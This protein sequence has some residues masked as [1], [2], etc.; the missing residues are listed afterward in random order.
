MR[1]IRVE[2][3]GQ[4][5]NILDGRFLLEPDEIREVDDYT[6][7]N[8]CEEYPSGV[9]TSVQVIAEM[10]PIGGSCESMDE[11]SFFPSSEQCNVIL[12]PS[13][14]CTTENSRGNELSCIE[15]IYQLADEDEPE[16]E[17]QKEVLLEYE[18]ANE[19]NECIPITK[20]ISLID[21]QD[22]VD[23]TPTPGRVL[24][25]GDILSL[26]Q[27]KDVD[28]C[29]GKDFDIPVEVIVN[30]GPIESCGGFGQINFIYPEDEVC[31]LLLDLTCESSSGDECVLTFEK[32]QCN[33]H[34]CYIDFE[35]TGGTCET[36]SNSQGDYFSCMDN[37]ESETN[38]PFSQNY[39]VVQS[40]YHDHYIT[41]FSG[42]VERGSSFRVGKDWEYLENTLSFMIY[43][44]KDGVLLQKLDFDSSCSKPL[45]T[46]D[47]FGSVTAIAFGSKKHHIPKEGSA[48]NDFN[49][50][51]DIANVGLIDADLMDITFTFNGQSESP[52]DLTQVR[53]DSGS[54]YSNYRTFLHTASLNMLEVSAKVNGEDQCSATGSLTLDSN[55]MLAPT[56]CTGCPSRLTLRFTGGSCN[57]SSNHQ[58]IQCSDKATIP[59]NA[60]IIISDDAFEATFFQG[61]VSLGNEFEAVI[62]D[63]WS[64][65]HEKTV[66][67][68]MVM[69]TESPY[70]EMKLAQI[71][72][73][74][75]NCIEPLSVDDIYGALDITGW[76]NQEQ[77][78]VRTGDTE[79]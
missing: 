25:P 23:I 17:C 13:V 70:S 26:S 72:K 27:I 77:G 28:F 79:C 33:F 8:Y 47:V 42:F 50:K 52:D 36:S 6:L 11:L 21:D 73:F 55:C 14:E 59:T 74:S 56:K 62:N 12:N 18:L 46:G 9:T 35:F 1:G 71:I 2:R 15:Y 63:N 29:I 34:P 4:S 58:T 10:F 5:Q 64:N 76:T 7:L 37:Y 22:S 51:Y 61:E 68:V 24:C 48:L 19:G 40:L 57:Q 41:Y 75:S 69:D 3:F 67:R 16:V 39:V 43:D 32:H 66:V 53:I 30:D 65:N 38:I 49:F 45:F 54:S 44:E 78:E 60:Y 31:V 20:V